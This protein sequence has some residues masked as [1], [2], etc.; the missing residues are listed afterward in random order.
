VQEMD[1]MMQRGGAVKAI[2]SV[3]SNKSIEIITARLL[4]VLLL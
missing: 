2:V 4:V 3:A 1:G